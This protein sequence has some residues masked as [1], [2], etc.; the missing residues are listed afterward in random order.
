MLVSE[1]GLEP[2]RGVK[3]HQVL[4]LV[5]PVSTGVDVCRFVS[6]TRDFS[7]SESGVVSSCIGWLQPFGL[8]DGCIG[9]KC[10]GL[11]NRGVVPYRAMSAV[12]V[13]EWLQSRR[14][15]GALLLYPW[16]ILGLGVVVGGCRERVGRGR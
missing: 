6:Q 14:P 15:Y 7:D 2:P 13:A 4:S 16:V 1:K 5:T 9:G 10:A 11:V 12:L 8:C 3:P